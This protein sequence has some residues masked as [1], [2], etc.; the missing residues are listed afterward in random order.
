[1]NTTNPKNGSEQSTQTCR[2]SDSK[3]LPYEKLSPMQRMLVDEGCSS[4]MGL[5]HKLL[6]EQKKTF[7]PANK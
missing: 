1:M 5:Q 4:L 7:E 6:A 3:C 2:H